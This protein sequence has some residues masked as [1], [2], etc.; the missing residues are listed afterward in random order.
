MGAIRPGET[1]QDF[2]RR[3]RAEHGPPPQHVVDQVVAMKRTAA[4]KAPGKKKRPA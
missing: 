4:A 2:G 3:L 1:P